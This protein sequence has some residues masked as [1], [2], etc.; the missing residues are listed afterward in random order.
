MAI[1][2]ASFLSFVLGDFVFSFFLYRGH[3]EPKKLYVS[4]GD[5]TGFLSTSPDKCALMRQPDW[6]TASRLFDQ[7]GRESL[8]KIASGFSGS[9]FSNQ[10]KYR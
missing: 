2:T 8:F 9:S 3:R 7:V 6:E 5:V 4:V 10:G 1:A